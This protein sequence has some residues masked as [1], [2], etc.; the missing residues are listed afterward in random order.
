M[1]A[2]VL[3]LLL[4]HERFVLTTHVRPDGDAI[5]SELALAA[6]LKRMGKQVRIF[7]SDPHPENL[8]WLPGSEAL[9]VFSNAP[10]QLAAVAGADVVAVLDTNAQDRL[11]TLAEPVRNS[12]AV[13]VLIDHHTEPETWFDAAFAE[14]T[15]SSTGE[16]IYE[17][18]CAHDPGLIDAAIASALYAAIVTD[19]GSFRYSSVT[20]AVHRITA[21][22][23]ERGGLRPDVIYTAL[24]ETRTPQGLRL[25]ARVLGTL[26]IHYEGLLSTLVVSQRMLQETGASSEETE[27]FVNY[28]LS[29][30]GVQVG[31]IFTETAHG[32]KVSFRSKGDRHVDAWARALGGG[33]HRNASGAFIRRPLDVVVD[34]VIASAA[35]YLALPE[36]E[37]GALSDEDQE[38]LALFNHKADQ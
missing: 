29:V 2:A 13:K 11:G 35:D 6:F 20:P 17:L 37:G 7:N 14:D 8:D 22:L 18:I 24:Y 5:G 10:A 15:A 4:R 1:R 28:G 32:T 36:P 31:L 23:I 30:E 34:E 21:D 27:G 12:G 26:A 33:G 16:L 3:A 25:L 38:L 19:T 9:E